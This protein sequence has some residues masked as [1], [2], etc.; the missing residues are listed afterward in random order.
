MNYL[1]F[2]ACHRYLTGFELDLSF[3]SDK[4]VTVLCGPSGSGKTTV[5]EII[6]GLKQPQSGQIKVIGKTLLDTQQG[7]AVSAEYRRIGFVFQDRRLFPHLTVLGNLRFGKRR[8]EIQQDAI[9]FNRLIEVLDLA[10]LLKR[11]PANLS[12]GEQQRVALGRA[13]LTHPELLL[14]DEPMV[15]LDESLSNQIGEY[16]TCVI[17]EWKI[18]TLI[19]SHTS[20]LLTQLASRIILIQNGQLSSS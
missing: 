15:A 6:A 16:L 12:G 20:N 14:L 10:H 18:P 4:L 13:L 17:E 9:S 1:S 3:E 11:Y 19:V 5:L 2:Q 8:K 7:I